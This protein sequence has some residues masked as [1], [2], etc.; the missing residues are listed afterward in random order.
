VGKY[1]PLRERWALS[2]AQ[3]VTLTFKDIAGLVGGLPR[4]A[5]DHSAWW[6]NHPGPHVQADAWLAAG[7]R[8]ESFDQSRGV[9]TFVRAAARA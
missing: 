3:R 6:A 7:Y 5:W 4:S 1:D 8:V 9:V 2:G